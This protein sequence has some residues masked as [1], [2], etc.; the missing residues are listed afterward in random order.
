MRKLQLVAG[1]IV[2]LFHVTSAQAQKGDWQAVKD[3]PSGTRIS[4]KTRVWFTCILERATDEVLACD[5]TLD[6]GIWHS[7]SEVK[8]DRRKIHEVRLGSDEGLNTAVGA[9]VGGGAGAIIGAI[10]GASRGS[11][12]TPGIGAILVGGLGAIVGG[13]VG[14][15]FP[16]VHGKVVYKKIGRA[17]AIV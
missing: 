12:S 13:A 2:V 7:S 9:A 16:I 15:E 11:G 17:H 1:L 8:L 3:L 4:V 10:A 6:G 14:R 5:L